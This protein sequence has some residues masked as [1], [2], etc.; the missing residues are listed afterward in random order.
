MRARFG[1][2]LEL[3]ENDLSCLLEEQDEK[4]N[5]KKAAKVAGR[6]LNVFREKGPKECRK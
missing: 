2:S 1:G 6:G 5:N 4:K 3:S